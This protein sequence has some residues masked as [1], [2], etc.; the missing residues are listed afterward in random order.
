MN[1]L[2]SLLAALLCAALSLTALPSCESV[3]PQTGTILVTASVT[4]FAAK[5]V[6]KGKTEASMERRRQHLL[7][8]A[9]ALRAANGEGV[10]HATVRAALLKI[11]DSPEWAALRESLLLFIPPA[12]T[13]PGVS[14][15]PYVSALAAA[16]TSVGST[17]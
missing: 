5:Y 15:Y 1:K 13:S 16:L 12:G 6:A 17:T 4:G 11:D 3:S 8:A 2:R 7:A 10:D 14:R 9:A